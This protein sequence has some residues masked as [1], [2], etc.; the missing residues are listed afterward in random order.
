[1]THHWNHDV[2]GEDNLQNYTSK[3]NEESEKFIPDKRK[4][5]INF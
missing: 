2:F 4:S 5:N 1:M 3:T